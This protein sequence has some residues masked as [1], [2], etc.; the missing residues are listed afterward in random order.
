[1]HYLAPVS[2]SEDHTGKIWNSGDGRLLLTLPHD[3]EVQYAEFSSDGRHVITASFDHT[4]R[5]WSSA[6]G[7]LLA[8]LQHTDAVYHAA[9]APSDQRIATGGADHVCVCGTWLRAAP[10]QCFGG[11]PRI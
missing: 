11:M 10:Q 9:F 6:T 5:I 4:A 8:T 7:Q 3:G 1:M 2:L